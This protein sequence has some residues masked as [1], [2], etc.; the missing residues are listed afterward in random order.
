GEE[1]ISRWSL[2]DLSDIEEITIRRRY[3]KFFNSLKKRSLRRT[4]GI[5]NYMVLC[6]RL[7]TNRVLKK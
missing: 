6:R 2:D 3:T 1:V 7:N 4:R 5:Q